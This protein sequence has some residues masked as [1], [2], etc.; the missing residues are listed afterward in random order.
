M[1]QKLL[2]KL[3]G[4]CRVPYQ[5]PAELLKKLQLPGNVQQLYK[6]GGQVLIRNKPEV[7][8]VCKG[9]GYEAQR[10][11]FEV[12]PIGPDERKMIT[13]QDWSGLRSEMRKRKLPSIQ[14]SALLK[15]VEGETSMEEVSR[16]TSSSA[17]KKKPDRKPAAANPG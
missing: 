7:C 8:P 17:G 14:Q 12:Y 1:A 13:A 4:N 6:K 15:A 11:I 2:R 3:C 16:V 9:I 5:P 10:G